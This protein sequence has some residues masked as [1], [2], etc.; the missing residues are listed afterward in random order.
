[1]EL[2]KKS[3]RKT[4]FWVFLSLYA[5]FA[6]FIVVQSCLPGSVSASQSELIA[7]WVAFFA[8]LKDNG[9]TAAVIEPTA[10]ALKAGSEGDTTYLPPLNGVPQVALGTTTRLWYSVTYPLGSIGIEDDTFVVTATKNADCFSLVTDSGNHVVRIVPMK[11]CLGASISVQAGKLSPVSYSF[12]A[13]ALPSPTDYRISASTTDLKINESAVITVSSSSQN[14]TDFHRYY[15]PAKLAYSSSD[16]S[17]VSVTNDGLVAAKSEGTANVTVGSQSLSFTVSGALPAP[18]NPTLAVSRVSGEL[19]LQDYGLSEAVC[20]ATY[21]AVFSSLA[22]GSDKTVAWSLSNN[23]YLLKARIVSSGYDEDGNP[24]CH[25]MGYRQTGAIKVLCTYGND[26]SAHGSFDDE[27]MAVV[28]SSMSLDYSAATGKEATYSELPSS[29][30]VEKTTSVYLRGNFSP[31]L[32]SDASIY[33]TKSSEGLLVYGDKTAHITVSFPST[34]DF[35]LTVA[36]LSNPALT[37][38]VSF[39]VTPANVAPSN[40]TFHTWIRK[41]LGHLGLFVCLGVFGCLFWS[42]FYEGSFERT[43]W[44]LGLTNV[45]AGFFFAALSEAIQRIPALQRDG[46]WSDVGID[47]IGFVIGFLAVFL[48]F[49][50]IWLAKKIRHKETKEPLK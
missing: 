35:D 39:H 7:S 8:N 9:K 29:L 49:L 10:I 36:S 16:P 33:V 4:S 19:H 21:K 27:V 23:D 25:V 13:V 48:V 44:K 42:A 31:A 6:A 46:E 15:D 18:T 24:I 11:P 47:M 2:N 5:F 38:S 30:S 45:G 41:N 40:P 43:Y 1:M 50:T 14:Q 3:K 22:E 20:G 32:P 26:R 12:D 28:P 17:V 34:G 37:V